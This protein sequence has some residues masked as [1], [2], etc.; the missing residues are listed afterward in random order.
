MKTYDWLLL[1]F[2]LGDKISR[3]TLANLCAGFEEFEHRFDV[4]QT[5]LRWENQRLIRRHQTAKGVVYC[6]TDA[7]R[8]LAEPW[9]DPEQH[10]SRRWDGVWRVFL[11]DLPSA[12]R[13]L[14][15]M[16]W[17]WLRQHRFGYLQHSV[18]IRPEPVKELVETLSWFR[19][20]PEEFALL[21]SRRVTG[22]SDACL[23]QAAWD[24]DKVND[25]YHRYIEELSS[26]SARLNRTRSP[27][28][29]VLC[30]RSERGSY[31]DAL[32]I[33][34]LLPRRLLPPDYLGEQALAARRGFLK[35]V[36]THLRP[37]LEAIST[38]V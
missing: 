36:R 9:P 18:W 23:V 17:R 4:R 15:T 21:E 27:A 8:R 34:P 19:E 3:P 28:E 37:L 26:L 7:A 1:L 35:E 25:A 16:L 32:A 6:L 24:F 31:A 22:V 20:N 29:A 2:Y 13:K 14:R 12:D 10:W 5:L 30:L 11:F 33:D 38:A